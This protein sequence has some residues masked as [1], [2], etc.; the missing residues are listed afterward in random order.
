MSKSGVLT[1]FGWSRSSGVPR[2]KPP[3]RQYGDKINYAKLPD[4]YLVET[5]VNKQ[6]V[7]RIYQ[8]QMLQHQFAQRLNVVIL[9]MTYTRTGACAHVI[10]FSS[11]LA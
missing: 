6:I 9:H 1:R 4:K 8:A 5:S 3:P 2:R 10:L 11:D 7:T